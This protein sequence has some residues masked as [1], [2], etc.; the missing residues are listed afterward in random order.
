MPLPPPQVA[1]LLIPAKI[2]PLAGVV[3]LISFVLRQVTLPVCQN[4]KAARKS[5]R[6]RDYRPRE[7]SDHHLRQETACVR[8]HGYA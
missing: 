7:P 2:P 6:P 8:R 1:S 4:K 5:E 3:F